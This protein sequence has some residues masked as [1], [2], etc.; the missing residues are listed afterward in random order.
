[1]LNDLAV[2]VQLVGGMIGKRSRGPWVLGNLPGSKLNNS[3][4]H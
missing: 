2:V 1:M 3:L 4:Q